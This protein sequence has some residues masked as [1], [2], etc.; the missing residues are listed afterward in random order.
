MR[1]GCESC[2]I[3]S[4]EIGSTMLTRV[5]GSPEGSDEWLQR[6][7][8]LNAVIAAC[9][10]PVAGNLLY[11]HHQ[12]DFMHSSPVAFNRVKRDRFT[13]ACR[14]SGRMLEI[15]VNAGHSAYLALTANPSLEFHG[16]DIG[17]HDYVR[18]ATQW[19]KAQFPGRV[20]FYEGSCLD[21]LPQL[22]KRGMEFDLFHIDGAKFTYYRDILNSQRMTGHDGALIVID[23]LNMGPVERVWERSVAQGIIVPHPEFPA[24]PLTEEHRNAIGRLAPAGRWKWRLHWYAGA[25]RRFRQYIVRQVRRPCR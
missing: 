16:V 20:F 9:G 23:D 25:L 5:N 19:L 2:S 17:E 10:E 1:T 22:A 12:P 21:V 13:H 8:E 4:G 11:D 15:G 7:A 6:L 14:L 24:M 18:P 3:G